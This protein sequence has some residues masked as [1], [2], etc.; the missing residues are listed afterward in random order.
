MSLSY[1]ALHW[2]LMEPVQDDLVRAMYIISRGY[3]AYSK[4]RVIYAKCTKD[5]TA[6]YTQTESTI[7]PVL[8]RHS[9]EAA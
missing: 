9:L 4:C 5:Q 6:A 1:G 3:L 7:R 2:R 8:E